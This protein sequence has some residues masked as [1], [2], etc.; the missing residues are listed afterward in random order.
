ML[1]RKGIRLAA[2]LS[3]LICISAITIPASA[4]TCMAV[5][6][7]GYYASTGYSGTIISATVSNGSSRGTR[8][9]DMSGKYT[10][11]YST[12]T[13]DF[14]ASASGN[15]YYKTATYNGGD[16]I[17]EVSGEADFYASAGGSTFARTLV[18]DS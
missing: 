4:K 8:S 7:N 17:I 12:I 16:V 14:E 18:F 2:L 3:S 10:R 5:E 9:V 15:D 13:Y 6:Y 1:K 11:Q